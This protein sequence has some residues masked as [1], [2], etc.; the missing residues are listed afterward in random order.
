VS[1]GSSKR[2]TR[3]QHGAYDVYSIDWAGVLSPEPRRGRLAGRTAPTRGRE[4]A[5]P[6]PGLPPATSGMCPG[7]VDPYTPLPCGP[8]G[9]PGAAKCP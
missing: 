5:W 4:R 6:M 1:D 9:E 3:S 8:A 2:L 7:L